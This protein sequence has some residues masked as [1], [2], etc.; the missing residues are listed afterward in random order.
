LE[1]EKASKKKEKES[2]AFLQERGGGKRKTLKE[3]IQEGKKGALADLWGKRED[4]PLVHKKEYGK[5]KRK[6]K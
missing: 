6:R 1:K 3:A 5:G 4:F 2:L